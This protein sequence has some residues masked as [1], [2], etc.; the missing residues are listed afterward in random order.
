MPKVPKANH[1][2]GSSRSAGARR[3]TAALLLFGSAARA[4]D[5]LALQA[6][7]PANAP[8]F[9]PMGFIQVV[10]EGTS[11]DPLRGLTGEEAAWNGEQ[12]SAN[13]VGQ[14][15][16]FAF[17]LRRVRLG[18]RG[19]LD[20]AP[21]NWTISADLGQNGLTRATAVGLA[22][23]S[24]TARLAPG[25][26]IRAGRFKLPTMDEPYGNP[27]YMPHV[28]FSNTATQLI[29]ESRVRDGATDGNASGFRD[30]GVQV[31]DSIQDKGWHAG[32]AVM[33]SNGGPG[34]EQDEA[35]DLTFRLQGGLVFS[36]EQ[37]DLDREELS[38]WAWRQQ[39][40][41]SF[42]EDLV[43]A[44]VRQ[45]AGVGFHVKPMRGRVEVVQAQGA[46]EFAPKLAGQPVEVK[47]GEA[48]GIMAD[49][50]GRIGPAELAL[51]WDRLQKEPESESVS[52]L[53][54]WTS[55]ASWRFS[56]RLALTLDWA[57][58][59]LETDSDSL[60]AQVLAD[61]L[62][63]RFIGQLSVVF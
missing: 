35:K 11:G 60:N 38:A 32:Y 39:G 58:R 13:T 24:V 2:I 36:G 5:N 10:G 59:T 27:N 46:L 21:V 28:D 22:D 17:T 8:R 52:L 15:S 26:K 12:L 53:T 25:L 19:Q 55:S 61:A 3:L 40:E 33:A 9:A 42:D 47:D 41:R 18:A 16:T 54:T 48:L 34:L 51:R 6:T 23:A 30:T 49:L 29:L 44:R 57:H 31:F 14:G 56:P 37:R 43:M 63:D 1:Q 4:E 45:G 7:E 50:A 20:N 62:A